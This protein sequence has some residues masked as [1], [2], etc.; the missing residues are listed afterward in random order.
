MLTPESV[1]DFKKRYLLVFGKE[2]SDQEALD[3]GMRLIRLVKTVYGDNVPKKWEPKR[4]KSNIDKQ[5][6]KN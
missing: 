6:S 3:L 1:A 2:I 4:E 5:G